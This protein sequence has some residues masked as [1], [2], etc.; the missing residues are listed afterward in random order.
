VPIQ[1]IPNGVDLPQGCRRSEHSQ[2][3]DRAR[4]RRTALF[5][6]RI[7][8]VKGLPMLIEAWARVQP[9]G[10]RLEIAGPDE[11]KHQA[12]VEHAV[13]AASL[14][15]VVS[16]IGPVY[17]SAKRSALFNADLL[18][19]PSHSESFGMVV[20]EA[21][22]HGLPVLTTTATPWSGAAATRLRLVGCRHG[23][24][25]RRRSSTSYIA[26]S[27]DTARNGRERARVC[28]GGIRMGTGRAA[29]RKDLSRYVGWLA[30]ETDRTRT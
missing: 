28:R 17:G 18:V 24:R 7:Y 29:V 9:S 11:A 15:E 22:A 13:A 14:S 16:F 8:P 25:H 20:A 3:F 30:R 10:W 4:G 23:R 2:R 26:G 19:L 12:E 1:V 27:R 6:G 21:L 5:I